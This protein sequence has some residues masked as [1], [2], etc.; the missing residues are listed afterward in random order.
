MMPTIVFFETD[1]LTVQS[2]QDKKH[3]YIERW[4]KDG[5]ESGGR[6]ELTTE[7]LDELLARWLYYRKGI[8]YPLNGLG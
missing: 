1:T 4:Y 7:E 2:T 8:P 5:T 3:I 6:V